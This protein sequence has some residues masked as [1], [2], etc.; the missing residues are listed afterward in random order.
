MENKKLIIRRPDPNDGRGIII[1]LTK[2]GLKKRKIVIEKIRHFKGLVRSK[3]DPSDLD[4]FH[5]VAS[6]VN[7]IIE[8]SNVFKI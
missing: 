8:K 1:S 5:R 3:I 7:D 4:A 6:Q 2:L